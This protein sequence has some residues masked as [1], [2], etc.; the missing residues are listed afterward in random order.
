MGHSVYFLNHNVESILCVAEEKKEIIG[1]DIWFRFKEGFTNAVR[2]TV[3]ISD[4][5]WTMQCKIRTSA[6]TGN[7]TAIS[8]LSSFSL[9]LFVIIDMFW[10]ESFYVK[11]PLGLK[12][13]NTEFIRIFQK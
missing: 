5:L 13:N 8:S 9:L 2:K 10:N 3:R 6:T 7:F 12:Y 11:E 4:L 1:G